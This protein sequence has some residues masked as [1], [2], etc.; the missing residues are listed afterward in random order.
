MSNN[1]NTGLVLNVSPAVFN[2]AEVCVE[3]IE[4]QGR[5][6]LRELRS[7][8]NTTHIFHR[9]GGS[10]ILCIPFVPNA[11]EIGESSTTIQLQSNLS[12]A[13]ALMRNALLNH[14]YHL[15]HQI[16]TY[17]PIKFIAEGSKNNIL[18]QPRGSSAGVYR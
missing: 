12:L 3:I 7:K 1:L 18:V 4:Y 8:H 5:E 9:D 14:F 6:Q 11:P 2:E 15:R 17:H 16:L 13:A 10:R